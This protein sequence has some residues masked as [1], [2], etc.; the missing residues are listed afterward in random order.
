M[1][2]I[3][4]DISFEDEVREYAFQF[5]HVHY[6]VGHK[7]TRQLQVA[8]SK[9]MGLADEISITSINKPSNF[10]LLKNVHFFQE[11]PK[12]HQTKLFNEKENS[13]LDVFILIP[14]QIRVE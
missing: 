13:L 1:R 8:E 11:I 12:Y 9:L 7:R 14:L 10:P 4:F 3:S 5:V 6:F 2:H